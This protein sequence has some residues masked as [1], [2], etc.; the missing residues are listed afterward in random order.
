MRQK[1]AKIKCLIFVPFWSHSGWAFGGLWGARRRVTFGGSPTGAPMGRN[2]MPNDTKKKYFFFGAFLTSF[3]VGVGWPVWWPRSRCDRVAVAPRSHSDSSRSRRGR[4]AVL[5][6]RGRIA[7]RLVASRSHR[8]A[9]AS[10]PCRVAS[11]HARVLAPSRR[12]RAASRLRRVAVVSRR[13]VVA[14]RFG[15]VASRRVAR[16]PRRGC[17]VSPSRRRVALRRRRRRIVSPSPSPSRRR[18]RR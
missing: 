5:S 4:V 8:V 15:V 17:V 10:R 3:G 14:S 11:R 18:R 2:V 13:V 9:V 1:G 7:S 6:R 16:W 12:H